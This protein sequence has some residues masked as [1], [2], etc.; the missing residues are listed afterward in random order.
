MRGGVTAAHALGP[1]KGIWTL[2]G[3]LSREPSF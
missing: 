2:G 1:L 3:A